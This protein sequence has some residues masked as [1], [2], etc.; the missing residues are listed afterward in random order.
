MA[1]RV[2]CFFIF[3]RRSNSMRRQDVQLLAAA[4][5]GDARARC[6]VGRRYLTGERGFPRHI[7]TAFDYLNHPSVSSMPE[8]AR[9]VADCLPLEDLLS[10][11]QESLLRVAAFAGSQSGQLKLG[12]W[13]LLLGNEIEGC[14]MLK[15]AASAGHLAASA[16]LSALK[17][18]SG[19]A[20]LANCLLAAA[21][22]RD[23]K[24]Q[25]VL[26]AAA[27]VAISGRDI[28]VASRCLA[29]ALTLP[30]ET[31]PEIAE[32]VVSA[33][34]LAEESRST[35]TGLPARSVQACLEA[36]CSQ[37]DDDAAFV[38][39]RA[40]CGIPCGTIPSSA[41]V[42]DANM[43]RAAA[44]LVRSADSGRVAAWLHLYNLHIDD[45]RTSVAN[46]QMARYYLEKAAG[47]G[48]I[49]AQQI[50]G[51][52]VL[53]EARGIRESERGMQLLFDAA[54]SGD[55]LA[56]RLLET[57]VL[58][59]EGSD[60]ETRVAI[61]DVARK[62]PWLAARLQLSRDFGLTRLEALTVNPAEGARAWGLVV[63]HNPFIVQARLSAPRAIPALSSQALSNL[64][65][66][67]A[68][69]NSTNK[70]CRNTEGDLRQRSR[71][72]RTVFDRLNLDSR[73]FFANAS[74]TV[75]DTL[76]QGNKWTKRVSRLLPVAIV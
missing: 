40:L 68:Q 17:N 16:A 31:H 48:V 30:E 49:R 54:A 57:F 1:E 76:R 11:K 52:S 74:S 44:M 58:P 70:D 65:S 22:G 55:Q 43:R 20:G 69:F 62:S 36:R 51:A 27:R 60:A 2:D 38:L 8:V 41:L 26:A 47:A 32:L 3:I 34:K 63:G 7:R 21:S 73:L 42:H 37:G 12:V 72:Q 45:K 46:K 18:S 4:R 19:S 67:A 29:L 33:I 13:A 50:L 14:R 39:G 23:L 6:E 64:R 9:L 35:L 61:D 53:A 66:I 71:L 59:L 25:R 5:Q 10:Y 24:P 15:M 75:L 56:K 28:T